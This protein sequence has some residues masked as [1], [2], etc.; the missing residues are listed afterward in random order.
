MSYEKTK[1]QARRSKVKVVPPLITLREA[2]AILGL[3]AGALYKSNTVKCHGGK[4]RDITPVRVHGIDHVD[5]GWV[6]RH[7]GH[8]ITMDE[9]TLAVEKVTSARK[10]RHA[11]DVNRRLTVER[12]DAS[13]VVPSKPRN[14]LWKV[15]GF[16]GMAS[17]VA[18]LLVA[19]WE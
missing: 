4:Y 17:V 18:T 2:E 1:Y 12:L 16:S 11:Y 9:F 5:R 13:R 7:L 6:E 10:A 15:F 3:Y 19:F 14:L 8:A